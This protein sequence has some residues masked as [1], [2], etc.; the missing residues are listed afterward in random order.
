MTSQ[1]VS[2]ETGVLYSMLN[3]WHCRDLSSVF[4]LYD[5]T[6]TKASPAEQLSMA[7]AW[8]RA[9][10]AQKDVLVSGQHW[11]VRLLRVNYGKL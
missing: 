7:L 3:L 1:N 2:H 11:Q 6:G 8:D 5:G 10:I 9:D 4:A